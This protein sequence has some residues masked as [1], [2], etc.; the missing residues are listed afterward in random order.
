MKITLEVPVKP[1]HGGQNVKII[2]AIELADI[3]QKRNQK[4]NLR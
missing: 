4:N 2:G 1:R 3:I